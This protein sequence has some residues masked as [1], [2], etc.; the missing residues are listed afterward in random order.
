MVCTMLPYSIFANQQPHADSSYFPPGL[1]KEDVYKQLLDQ[2]R[3]LLDGQRNWVCPPRD[4]H[5]STNRPGEV[6]MRH[7][8]TS[9]PHLT[10]NSNLSNVASLLWHAYAAL[11]APSSVNWAGFYI[12]DDKFPTL[13]SPV[14][15]QSPRASVVRS[16]TISIT[17]SD[18]QEQKLLLGPFQG[19]PACQLIVFGKGVCGTAAMKQESLVVDDVFNFPGH[20]ACD[21]DSRSE[22]VVPILVDGEVSCFSSFRLLVNGNRLSP[23][24]ISTAPRQLGSTMSTRSTWRNWRGFWRRAVTGNSC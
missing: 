15:S 24:L 4:P 12:R 2:T 9:Q 13:A 20:I 14:S 10:S 17:Y 16:T 5:A 6:R 3:G 23:S 7:T 8:P 18:S 22:V 19:K 1:S 11:P 21:A